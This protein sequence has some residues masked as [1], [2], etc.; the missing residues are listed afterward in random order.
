MSFKLWQNKLLR[1]SHPISCAIF[2]IQNI[3]SLAF[4]LFSSSLFLYNTVTTFE[5]TFNS[6]S[7]PFFYIVLLLYNYYELC[8][9]ILPSVGEVYT[10]KF[11]LFHFCYTNIVDP[12]IQLVST[13]YV[14]SLEPLRSLKRYKKWKWLSMDF[15]Y[16]SCLLLLF[17]FFFIHFI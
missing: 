10:Y 14:Q 7:L 16:C 6:N 11:F 15:Y 5:V 13:E 3:N 9:K 2:W 12:F 1:Y 8:F 4:S 17:D